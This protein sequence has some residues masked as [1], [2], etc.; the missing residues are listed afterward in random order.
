EKFDVV[1]FDESSQCDIYAVNVLARG[2]K[3]IVVGDD[4]QISPESIGVNREDVNDL[5][6]RYIPEIPNGHLFDGKISLYEIAEQVFPKEGKLMLREHF[7]CV[8]EI[9]QFSNDLSYG[10]EM[11]PLRLPIETEKV[12]PPVTAIHVKD[13]YND[14]K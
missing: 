14:L 4:E 13:G 6:R 2:K 9:I 10:G 11:I 1:I 5:V 3:S 12:D 7:R 8:P